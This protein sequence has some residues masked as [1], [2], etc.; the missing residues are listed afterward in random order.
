MMTERER[1]EFEA[2][3]ADEV[4]AWLRGDTSRRSFLTRM[5]LMGGAAIIQAVTGAVVESFPH[6]IGE[7]ATTA[8]AM[9]YAILAGLTLAALLVYRRVR[10]I[11]GS[12]PKP[13]AFTVPNPSEN[14]L[15][16]AS[17]GA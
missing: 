13:A 15:R 16:G 8:Y 4:S 11:D 7:D 17:A 12:A 9:L 2:G 1:R 3:L 6:R 14:D 5:L 10:D